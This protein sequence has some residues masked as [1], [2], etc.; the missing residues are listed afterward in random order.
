[1]FAPGS[2]IRSGKEHTM[3]GKSVKNR[4]KAPHTI[5]TPDDFNLL[6]KAMDEQ[7]KLFADHYLVTL[8]A[9]DSYRKAGYKAKGNSTRVNAARLLTNANVEKYIE[10]KMQQRKKKLEFDEK[11]VITFL[12]NTLQRDITD[13]YTQGSDGRLRLKDL[14]KLTPEKKALIEEISD[15][16]QGIRIK[17]VSFQ[18]GI[19]K[20]GAHL[21]M[22][23]KDKQ[24]AGGEGS[25][26][27]ILRYIVP[28]VGN[29]MIKPKITPSDVKQIITDHLLK[30]KNK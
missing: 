2:I 29:V 30:E 15:T 16:Q 18:N 26:Y 10:W 24:N 7:H 20:L 13:Y 25:K 22:W 23:N 9:A 14:T 1:M 21:G 8:N 19:D 6:C 4:P 3:A 17:L 12:K 28:A 5:N 27:I 11:F